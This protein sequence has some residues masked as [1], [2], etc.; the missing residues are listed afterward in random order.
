MPDNIISVRGLSKAF[1]KKLAVDDVDLDVGSGEIFG[2]LG[3][4]GAGKTTAIRL[5]TTLTNKDSGKIVINGYDIDHEQIEAKTSIGV[6]QQHVSLD[7]DLTVSEN[8]ICHAR[9]HKMPKGRMTERIEE[10][11]RYLGIDEYRD[12]KVTSLS[13]GWKRRVSVACA[14]IHEPRILFLDE[15]TVGLDIRARRLIWDVIRKLNS[16]GT[17]VFLTTHYIEEAETLC[18]RVAFINR[19]R[20]VTV[21]T[22]E[23][24]RRSVGNVAVESFAN[25]TRETTY[26]YFEDRDLANRFID[27]L[28]GNHT[29]TVRN[30]NLE[31]CFVEMTG[32]TVGDRE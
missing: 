18:D 5:M 32:D 4:N 6:V 31:D 8:M 27:T 28:D 11:I 20:I 14:L 16:D 17:T 15:P 29:V 1:G 24:L 10:L 12:Y 22:P 13:G 19:G 30:V 3:P 23:E 26:R 7:N 2:F 9:Y 21:G 25:D